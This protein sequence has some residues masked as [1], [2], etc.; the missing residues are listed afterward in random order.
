MILMS[1]TLDINMFWSMLTGSRWI[2][3]DSHRISSKIRRFSLIF[4][5][6]HGLGLGLG[7]GLGVELGLGLGLGHGLGWRSGLAELGWRS[8]AGAADA[9]VAEACCVTLTKR[10][11]W[12]N[13]NK[14]HMCQAHTLIHF[15]IFLIFFD[16]KFHFWVFLNTIFSNF[17]ELNFKN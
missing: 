17:W 12:R 14:G 6:P 5:P 13:E 9:G 3:T 8:W 7:L 15:F 16:T 1:E 2:W 4:R 11:R 10:W